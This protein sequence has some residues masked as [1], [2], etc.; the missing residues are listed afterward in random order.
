MTTP[1]I[2]QNP[3]PQLIGSPKLEQ[4]KDQH[5]HEIIVTQQATIGSR[6]FT[7]TLNLTGNNITKEMAQGAM[8]SNLEKIGALVSSY[9]LGEKNEREEITKTIRFK[10]GQTENEKVIERV[11][12]PKGELKE[13]TER[14][15]DKIDDIF[16][17]FI[18]QQQKN[19]T[20][21]SA[22][23]EAG[24][25]KSPSVVVT[26]GT[27]AL[28]PTE[29]EIANI[30][31]R[32]AAD[33]AR[34]AAKANAA[35]SPIIISAAPLPPEA[36]AEQ[37]PSFEQ[38]NVLTQPY[39][40]SATANLSSSNDLEYEFLEKG[41]VAAK[42]QAIRIDS[43]PL[44]LVSLQTEKAA[45]EK[46]PQTEKN[47]ERLAELTKKIGHYSK[48]AKPG[49][50]ATAAK[51]IST[52]SPRMAFKELESHP[53]YALAAKS[54]DELI[55]MALRSTIGYLGLSPKYPVKRG[56][57]LT[58][59][60]AKYP[61]VL[62]GIVLQNYTEKMKA[63][64]KTI[65]EYAAAYTAVK[66]NYFPGLMNHRM[67]VV[68]GPKEELLSA[69]GRSGAVSDF[70]HGEISLQELQDYED[71][72]KL[73]NEPSSVKRER[74]TDLVKLYGLE[75]KKE[76]FSQDKL[77]KLIMLL[78]GKALKSYGAE[79]LLNEDDKH[80]DKFS[81]A[82]LVVATPL[83]KQLGL[84]STKKNTDPIVE[85][86][87][88]ELD[89]VELSPE[90]LA[91]IIAQRKEKLTQQVLQD[92]YVH[93]KT[94]PASQP[95]TLFARTGLLDLTKPG[96]NEH[97]CILHE[98]TQ[99]LDTWATYKY[100]DGK[101]IKFD[102]DDSGEDVGPYI[103]PEDPEGVIHM[104]RRCQA[105]GRE[106]TVLNTLYFN[107]SVQGNTDNKGLQKAINDEA[108]AKM[109][110]L[111]QTSTKKEESSDQLKALQETLRR[112]P[113]S[114]V[115]SQ[116]RAPRQIIQ[117]VQTLNGY[118]SV[119]CYGGKD[120]TGYLLAVITD[121]QL[122]K[123]LVGRAKLK[124][125]KLPEK[126]KALRRNWQKQLLANGSVGA[127]IAYENAEHYV[128]KLKGVNLKLVTLTNTNFI[129]AIANRIVE[130]FKA[131]RTALRGL[132]FSSTPDQLYDSRFGIR[133]VKVSP[134]EASEISKD[135]E[136]A[137]KENAVQ[138]TIAANPPIREA[139]E[140]LQ[141][142]LGANFPISLDMAY[143]LVKMFESRDILEKFNAIFTAN[144]DD[145]SDAINDFMAFAA[146]VASVSRELLT[147]LY[148]ILLAKSGNLWNS[149]LVTDSVELAILS[150]QQLR[151]TGLA[152]KGVRY[153]NQLEN[154]KNS[155]SSLT[156]EERELVTRDFIPTA[157]KGI[158]GKT[159]WKGW[160]ESSSEQFLN[161]TWE[162]GF[163]LPGVDSVIK[164]LSVD[165]TPLGKMNKDQALNYVR[166]M[167]GW[168]DF[169]KE[170]R[171][172]YKSLILQA[173]HGRDKSLL[174]N[175]E[176]L[177]SCFSGADEHI[178][179]AGMSKFYLFIGIVEKFGEDM[180]KTLLEGLM[181]LGK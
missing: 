66:D 125:E 52:N 104:P 93:L 157:Y 168:L 127:R 61:N 109:E 43:V 53:G 50:S 174:P 151:D 140:S 78:K 40:R 85:S 128:Y 177:K 65:Q 80:F 135:E 129:V 25:T 82:K 62:K 12:T 132:H 69:T 20:I 70:G 160:K 172:E 161:L 5:A 79:G 170:K 116:F 15:T 130:W 123:I 21:S 57:N 30:Q 119:N 178:W 88:A 38:A 163:A 55:E 133:T 111:V 107:N 176:R 171:D 150:P 60:N 27:I 158:W 45:L 166:L 24:P 46:A 81:N 71:L 39:L 154:A 51:W 77:Q 141:N 14:I 165:L 117:L 96:K 76:A 139:L 89:A 102:I 64:H 147:D 136:I 144:T 108:M 35:A 91:T 105:G 90:K 22:S 138:E 103:D 37:L 56:M 175:E 68:T 100:L 120:R 7:I 19:I 72:L 95:E 48:I 173:F 3:I 181:E 34:A 8:T 115:R 44:L 143:A 87:R 4:G 179:K 59:F 145:R 41:V 33:Q 86:V 159:S 131:A 13:K 73:S 17:Q 75:G 99:G 98:R 114:I 134:Q 92:I 16:S 164:S 2:P 6:V 155:R 42:E 142:Y 110:K 18:Q 167:Q 113:G 153:L 124:G 1:S 122:K 149:Q 11:F 54:E 97:G 137:F 148:P 67:Q 36:S 23:L 74:I 126:E 32:A 101:T 112:N 156:P 84:L 47:D 169:P 9:K 63:Y 58:T 10:T 121:A 94:R 28:P 29:Q 26:E 118:G 146:N 152:K 106:K 49:G 180:E 83:S 162:G 31:A